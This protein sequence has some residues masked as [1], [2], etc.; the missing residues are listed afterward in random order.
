MQFTGTTRSIDTPK[1]TDSVGNIG[2]LLNLG[3]QSPSSNTV[4]P[5]C[6]KEKDITG[7]D[8][9]TRQ[10]FREGIVSHPAI[11]LVHRNRAGKTGN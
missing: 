11:I 6:G 8:G 4:N 2:W 10:H 7:R 1:I 9:M 5:A 3:N